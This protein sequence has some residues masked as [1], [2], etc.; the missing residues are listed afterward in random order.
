L[1]KKRAGEDVY[2]LKY[3]SLK[4]LFIFPFLLF[5]ITSFAVPADIKDIS[6]DKYFQAVHEALS[7]SKDSIYIAMYEISMEPDNTESEA[8]KLVQDIVDAHIRGVKVEVYLDRTKTYNE[9]KNNS[10]FLALYKK[11]VPVKFI[12]PGKRVHDKLIVID[13]F[14]VISGS[15]NWSYSAFRLNSE[16]ADLIISGEYAKEKL[17]NILKLRPLLD[18]RSIDEAQIITIKCPARFLKDK[19]L[20]P[21]MVTRRD[22]RAFDLY[23]FL[24]KEPGANYEDIA[25][26]LGILKYGK[27]VYRNQIIKTLKRLI[28]YGLAKVTFNYGADF[29]IALNTDTLGKGY[30]NIPLAYWKYGWSNK[31][32]QNAKFAYLIN[33]YKSALAKDNS[34]WSLS[35]RFLA[36]DFYVDPITIRTGMRELEKYSVLEIKRARIAKGAGY[37]DRKPNQYLLGMLYSEIDLEK[38]WRLLEERYGKD[39]SV[40]ARELSFMLDRGYNPGAVENI[41]RIIEEYGDKN[42]ARAVKIV[43]SMRPDNPLRNIGYVVGILRHAQ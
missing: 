6:D 40:R 31:L 38:K 21:M 9:D 18:K 12:A 17:K 32:S 30:F 24:L 4:F 23:L 19:S 8:Y 35:L 36:Q 41:I 14:I 20:A 27:T 37:E 33:I 5:P 13:K 25:K 16:N 7:K 10:A 28:G 39:L 15:S 1:I 22:D 29:K 2:R 3:S 42:T 43:S 26:E 11:G 34:W